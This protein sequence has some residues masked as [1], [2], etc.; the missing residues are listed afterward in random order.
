MYSN[1][2]NQIQNLF[3]MK[4]EIVKGISLVKSF[5]LTAFIFYIDMRSKSLNKV[6]KTVQHCY[7]EVVNSCQISG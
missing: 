6:L 4:N 1:I 2:S 5:N 3:K 7:Q